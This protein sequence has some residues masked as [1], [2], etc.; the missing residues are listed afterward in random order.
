MHTIEYKNISNGQYIESVVSFLERYLPI[1]P[2]YTPIEKSDSEWF[3]NDD[4]EI[5]FNHEAKC[6]SDTG[7]EYPFFFKAEPKDR[8]EKG[9]PDLG[10]YISIKSQRSRTPFFTIECKRLPTPRSTVEEQ[11]EYVTG[12]KGGIARFKRNEHGVDLAI[13]AMIGYVEKED[14]NYWQNQINSWILELDQKIEFGKSNIKDINWT[15]NEVLESVYFKEIARLHSKH[16]RV[17]SIL[18]EILL[19]HFWVKVKNISN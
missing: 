15:K 8:I 14:F 4:L 9:K 18:T 6:T 19:I 7:E 5:F 10:T 3:L 12:L 1:F 2:I 17:D 11:K 13:N 16:P